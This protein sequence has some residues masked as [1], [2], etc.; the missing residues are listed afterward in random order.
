MSKKTLLK[1]IA[2]IGNLNRAFQHC[3]KGKK[4]SVACQNFLLSMPDVFHF[5]RKNI[6]NGSYPWL[7]YHQIKVFDP[8]ERDILVAPFRDR[9]LHQ[10]ISQII[11][12]SIDKEIPNNSFACRQDMGNRYAVL[13]LHGFLKKS[14][15]HRYC[16]KLDVK[17]YF[18]SIDHEILINKLMALIDDKQVLQLLTS[19]IESH[20]PFR[21][22]KC[23]IPIGNVSS[24]HF[25][26][27]YLSRI[28][29]LAQ[30]MN[31]LFYI[32][33]MDDMVIVADNKRDAASFCELLK[34][35][36]SNL[37]LTVPK[38][39]TVLLGKDPIPFLGFLVSHDFIRP[40]S[41][42]LRRH[43]RQVR[44]MR[45]GHSPLSQ[46]EEVKTSFNAWN[47]IQCELP[48]QAR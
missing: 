35:R 26:N 47:S 44:R 15:S 43:K 8:K 3:Q 1:Q 30:E 13:K 42:N 48:S 41:R 11:A 34:D 17:R 40:L 6:L 27:L 12:P 33:Y 46:I 4:R 24:Q 32:R 9:V 25:A 37:R 29:K 16:I 21:I 45:K 39:K 23:G 10:A 5:M 36:I 19:L 20:E 2:D 22:R 14:G 38:E 18:N 28:D 7:P 31:S